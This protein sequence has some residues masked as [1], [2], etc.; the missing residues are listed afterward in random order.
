M[1][2]A[3]SL[4]TRRTQSLMNAYDRRCKRLSCLGSIQIDWQGG[5]TLLAPVLDVASAVPSTLRKATDIR[6][7]ARRR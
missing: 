2:W 5:C 3:T 7:K 6:V 1:G 4:F